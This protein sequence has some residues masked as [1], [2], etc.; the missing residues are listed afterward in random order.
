MATAQPAL[1]YLPG[2]PALI[3]QM[4]NRG[5][6][7]SVCFIPDSLQAL[8]SCQAQ[9]GVSQKRGQDVHPHTEKHSPAPRG[10]C[11]RGRWASAR[12]LLRR[13]SCRRS[14]TRPR[15]KGDLSFCGAQELQ[16]HW[17]IHGSIW[18]EEW[19]AEISCCVAQVMSVLS[20][21]PIPHHN[22]YWPLLGCDTTFPLESRGSWWAKAAT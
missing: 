12:C 19:T 17:W 9:P 18:G 15:A 1:N 20:K 13:D 10:Q 8:S 11:S 3:P 2:A 14:R 6:R 4:K 21:V 16:S 22:L 5:T 7:C